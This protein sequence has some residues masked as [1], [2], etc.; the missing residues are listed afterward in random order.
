[1][2]LRRMIAALVAATSLLAVWGS[3]SA[4][5]YVL[6]AW[7]QRSN[8]GVLSSLFFKSGTAQGCPA[9]APF[10]QPCYNPAQAW[11][12][13]NSIATT[14]ANNTATW[15]WNGT[16]MTQTGGVLWAASFISSNPNATPVISDRATSVT[17]N[18]G[19][20]TATAA[21]YECV[22]GTFLTTVGANGCLNLTLGDDVTLN[23]TVA[24]NVGGNANCVNRVVL[25][26]D[27]STGNPRAVS[28]TAGGGGCDGI[29]GA[30]DL[31]NIVPNPRFLILANQ[32]NIVG[33]DG[34]YMFGRASQA[35]TSPCAA[36]MSIAG[37]SYMLFALPT[38][39]DG[40]GIIDVLD[41]CRLLSNATQVDSNG[42]GYGNRCDGDLNNNG[43][44]N[45]Q[46]TVL[47]RQQLGQPSVAPT[48]NAADINANGSVNA[49]DT[50]LYR[51]LL[52]APPGPSGPCLNTFPCPAHP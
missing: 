32:A 13:A 21:S 22:E 29:D 27:A 49:Q 34:C 39:T 30:F 37:A 7:H 52:A 20:L 45:A 3:V 9:A 51:Q 15:D 16:T 40:D 18:T 17:I 23:S 33:S 38:D 6:V 11:V 25:G 8:S 19:T 41:N 42:D 50:T 28:D 47:Y 44:T 43:S 4:A 26:D 46:D 36:D 31:Y 12:A 1:M 10:R 35:S 48:F 14:V 2:N 5:P 24:Y